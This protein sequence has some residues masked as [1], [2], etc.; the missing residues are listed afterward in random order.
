MAGHYNWRQQERRKDGGWTL[1]KEI[2][3]TVIA[4]LPF[5][6]AALAWGVSVERTQARHDAEIANLREARVEIRASLQR[7]EDDVKAIRNERS[8]R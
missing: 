1:W 6:F 7:I 5:A 8:G 2:V 4:L 3:G